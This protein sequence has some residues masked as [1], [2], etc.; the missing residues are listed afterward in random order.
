MDVLSEL[1]VK[2][3]DEPLSSLRE[4]G[5]ITDISNPLSVVMLILDF[6]AEVS[7]NGIL[8]FFGNSSGLYARE[9]IE[10]LGSIGCS[11]DANALEK[12]CAISEKAG[13]T[14]YEI[15]K[16]RAQVSVDSISSFN[17]LHGDKWDSAADEILKLEDGINFERIYEVLEV[18]V[19]KHK[20]ILLQYI[21]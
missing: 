17:K 16:D 21:L 1:S 7:M 10:V 5:K 13:M 4:N 9:T 15:Q 8:D 3:Y 19:N 6:E 2:I 12:M 14:F 18:Y 11:E 20:E